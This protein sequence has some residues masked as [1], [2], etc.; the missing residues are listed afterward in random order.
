MKVFYLKYC[1]NNKK[2]DI[3][4][5]LKI[6]NFNNKYNYIYYRLVLNIYKIIII[7]T[8]GYLNITLF[9]LYY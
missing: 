3:I 5:L 1:N 2:K 8:K 6:L 4:L 9:E 7:N